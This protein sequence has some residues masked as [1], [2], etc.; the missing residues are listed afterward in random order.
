MSSISERYKKIEELLYT[1]HSQIKKNGLENFKKV[2]NDFS[3]PHKKIGKVIH[4]TGT[5][6][7]GSVSYITMSLLKGLGYNVALYTSPHVNSLTERIQINSSYIS[8]KDFVEIF[9]SISDKINGMSF[10]EIMTL[11][12]FLYFQNRVDYS[13][14]EVGIGGMYDTTNVFDD[15]F[16]CFITSISYDHTD[17][18]GPTLKDITIQKSGII[19][20]ESLCVFPYTIDKSLKDIIVKRCIDVDAKFLEVSEYFNIEKFDL[21]EI[22]CYMRSYD[23]KYFFQTNLFGIKQKINFS[24]VI[25]AFEKLGFDIKNETLQR[26]FNN[27]PINCRFEIVRKNIGSLSKTFI[28]DGAHN[29]EAFLVFIENIKFFKIDNPVLVFSMLSTKKYDEVAEIIAKSGV[30]K[31]IIVTEIKNP[32]KENVYKIADLIA[33]KSKNIDVS[34][35]EDIELALRYA[36]NF[37]NNICVCG[38]FYL[39]SDSLKIIR[40]L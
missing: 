5:N 13:V 16:L 40:N 12:A 19:K 32:K 38:S 15:T 7:K 6:G 39:A 28:I 26:A 3:S 36:S 9:E 33:S 20:K 4:I 23:G 34:V 29:P 30:F 25:K 2:L 18:L 10:F 1:K 35:V 22:K 17:L 24:M 8:E 27:I 11:I 21:N 14:I 31:K 37:S